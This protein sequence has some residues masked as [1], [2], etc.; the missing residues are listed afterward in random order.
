MN[1]RPSRRSFLASSVVFATTFELQRAAWGQGF[2]AQ[3]PVC[4]LV[5]EQEEGPYYLHG[6]ALRSNVAENKPGIPLSLRIAILDARSCKPLQGVAVDMWSCDAMGL[7]SGFTKQNPMGPGGPPPNFD[8]QHP[9]SRPGSRPGPLGP[10]P[11]NHPTDKRTFLRGIQI[12]DHNGVVNFQTIVPGFYMGRTNHVHFQVRSGVDGAGSK[13]AAGHISH[14][15]QIF[16]PESLVA[17]L[18]TQEPYSGHQIHRTTPTE[19]AVFTDQHGESSTAKVDP[20]SDGRG[21]AAE[22]IASLDPTSTPLPAGR[23][24]GPSQKV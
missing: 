3:A 15:G 2:S 14:T 22:L 17:R 10:P 20:L 11:K 8:P 5:A 7:Y 21:Y 19:D 1:D 23:R 24:G 16:L 12:T 13:L 18:M 9:G 4:Q 6:E